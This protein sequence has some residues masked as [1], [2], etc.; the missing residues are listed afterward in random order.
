MI[1]EFRSEH[2]IRDKDRALGREPQ[3]GRGER[4][5]SPSEAHRRRIAR[6]QAQRRLRLQQ[7]QLAKVKERVRQLGRALSIG[8]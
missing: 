8:R 4:A 5:P 3:R 6:E 7:R 2:G 1:E